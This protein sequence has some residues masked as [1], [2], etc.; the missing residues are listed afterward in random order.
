MIE[1]SADIRTVSEPRPNPID[2]AEVT[3]KYSVFV[4][5]G[6]RAGFTPGANSMLNQTVDWRTKL[7]IVMAL[8][9]TLSTSTIASGDTAID[10]RMCGR[11][12][13]VL[14]HGEIIRASRMDKGTLAEGLRSRM[15]PAD[16]GTQAIEEAIRGERIGYGTR[17]GYN[18]LVVQRPQIAGLY[19]CLD[20]IGDRQIRPD[21]PDLT[22][23]IRAS[24][25]YRLPVLIMLE[26]NLYTFEKVDM[27]LFRQV[28]ALAE[29]R[30][31]GNIEAGLVEIGAVRVKYD[32]ID[33]M[34]G[35]VGVDRA[36]EIKDRLLTEHVF[37]LGRIAGRIP[38]VSAL[39]SYGF[40]REAFLQLEVAGNINK[41]AAFSTNN[42]ADEAI[43]DR[44]TDLSPDKTVQDLAVFPS[45]TRSNRFFIHQGQLWS[46][47]QSRRDGSIGINPV[48]N[49][50]L[51][52]GMIQV[53][54]R[55]LIIGESINNADEYLRA[56]EKKLDELSARPEAEQI[57]R[58]A[59]FNLF[60]FSE[61]AG[62]LRETEL[63]DRAMAIAT[64]HVSLEEFEALKKRRL[65]ANGEFILT[66]ED[67]N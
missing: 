9:P 2:V 27:D 13:V 63:R 37:N 41:Y 58:Q 11:A 29:E 53:G 23:I 17:T 15:M 28:Q 19:L 5:H 52:N 8:Q 7:D 1:L 30:K 26:G 16:K 54:N 48:Y 56:M 59:V 10:N 61:Q 50:L 34:T 40:G 45:I 47:S 62:L 6:I 42:A 4:I 44:L 38:D 35:H 33:T 55:T 57:V 3:K 60:G 49:R 39:L 21:L 46:Y 36:A 12:G 64:R 18:E 65:K 31:A 24:T 43:A 25:E 51:N 20:S 14:S 67:I 22:E 32:D 66:E